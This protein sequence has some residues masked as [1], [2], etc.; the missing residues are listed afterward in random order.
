VGSAR[1]RPR[2]LFVSAPHTAKNLLFGYS[3]LRLLQWAR[4]VVGRALYLSLRSEPPMSQGSNAPVPFP[5]A[6]IAKNRRDG[7]AGFELSNGDPGLRGLCRC[8][9][10]PVLSKLN[11]LRQTCPY[12]LQERLRHVKQFGAEF[13]L[14]GFLNCMDESYD[15]D[16]QFQLRIVDW[17]RP[18]NVGEVNERGN[19]KAMFLTID[20]V[21]KTWHGVPP[22]VRPNI[23]R[24]KRSFR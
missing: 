2:P 14:A 4:R 7:F 17:P 10:R 1:G 3:Y 12:L 13:G 22:E 8:G 21:A 11:A 24:M 16:R 23:S 15:R 19:F 5:N 6:T 9:L 18:M 20:F